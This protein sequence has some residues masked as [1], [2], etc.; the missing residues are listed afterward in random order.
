MIHQVIGQVRGGLRAVSH[1]RDL[2]SRRPPA[3][4]FA[5]RQNGSPTVY[6]LTPDQTAPRGGVRVNYRQVDLLNGL[7]VRASVLH[8]RPGFHCTWFDNSTT[9]AAAPE[10]TLGPEDVL[11]VPEF[12]AS[13]MHLRPS[14]PRKIIFN[15]GAYHT[16]DYAADDGPPGAPYTEVPNLAAIL[17]VSDDSA[18]LLRYTFPGLPVHQARAVVNRALFHP[19]GRP[20]GR[21]IAFVPRRRPLERRQLFHMLRARGVLDGWELCPI[22]GR[23]EAQTAGL[24]RSSALFLSFSEREGFGLP[25]VEAMASGCFVV[26]Y[27][28]L[29]G[30][31]YFDAADSGPVPDSDLL[32]FA[33]AV[34]RAVRRHDTEP[35]AFAASGASA[36]ARVLGRYAEEGLINDLLALYGPI[37]SL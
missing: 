15:Q 2:R 23:T 20:S 37:L 3:L 26:G 11:V 29:G 33:E 14:E 7:G 32:A 17:T 22:E 25:P 28:G 6:Y 9:V 10:V 30:R 27:S 24:M 1:A 31:E 13:G 35:E 18:A 4:R 34:E 16:F 36:S 21:R 8:S 19:E 12:F 5:D